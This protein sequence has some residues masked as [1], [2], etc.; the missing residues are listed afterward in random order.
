MSVFI[1]GKKAT[2]RRME[3]EGGLPRQQPEELDMG[4]VDSDGNT[5]CYGYGAGFL[6]TG[7][8]KPN[9]LLLQAGII[10][11]NPGPPPKV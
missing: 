4:K 2:Q 3:G 5:R 11:S 8:G 1:A 10:G 6:N 7:P 9:H